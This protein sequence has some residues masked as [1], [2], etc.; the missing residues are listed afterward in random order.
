MS[1]LDINN[2]HAET[3]G[4]QI[5]SGLQLKVMPG[6]VHAIMGPNG[7]GKSTFIRM[8]MDEVEIDAGEIDKQSHVTTGYL[9]QDGIEFAGKSAYPTSKCGVTD[10]SPSLITRVQQIVCL[11]VCSL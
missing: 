8:L 11:L 10:C 7:S 6:E 5:L 4:K 2:L 1:M 9:P 3:S